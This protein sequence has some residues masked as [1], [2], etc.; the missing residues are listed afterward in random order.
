MCRATVLQ[1]YRGVDK[2]NSLWHRGSNID[3]PV[4]MG[5]LVLVVLRRVLG[6]CS[7]EISC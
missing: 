3:I 5:L 6:F 4:P 2:F 1:L 7:F